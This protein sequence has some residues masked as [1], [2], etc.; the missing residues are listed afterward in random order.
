MPTISNCSAVPTPSPV[1][2]QVAEIF[3]QADDQE[4]SPDHPF[5]ERTRCRDWPGIVEKEAF[6]S[7]YARRNAVMR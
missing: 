4:A 5:P 7:P 1:G 3:S 2:E 6:S